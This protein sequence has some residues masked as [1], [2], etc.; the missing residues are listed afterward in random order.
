P[1]RAGRFRSALARASPPRPPPPLLPP[2]PEKLAADAGDLARASS[3]RPPPPLLPPP[4]PEKL[5]SAP[6]SLGFGGIRD[7]EGWMRRGRR[8]R[9]EWGRL[10]R[11][12]PAASS[13][14]ASTSQGDGAARA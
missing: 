14:P 2:P 6:T 11:N 10:G 1:H 13:A 3:P 12:I 4:P 9:R 7:E 5:A 8:R